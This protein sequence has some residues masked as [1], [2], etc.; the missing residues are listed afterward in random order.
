MR[1]S[2]HS[3]HARGDGAPP[4]GGST[5]RDF[6]PLPSCEG[7]QNEDLE[8]TVEVL[9]QS[10]P[11]MR[12]E[13]LYS[14]QCGFVKAFQSTPLMRGETKAALWPI[15]WKIISIH[16]PH[17]R[18]DGCRAGRLAWAGYFNPLPSCEGRRN[19]CRITCAR[20]NNFNPLPSCE[21]RRRCAR[22]TV[23]GQLFQSTPL[24]RGETRHHAKGAALFFISIHSPHARG[25]KG[26]NRFGD[27]IE[28]SIHSPHARGD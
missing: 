17:A 15:R 28:I 5:K 19:A 3:P 12:G 1:I 21:G 27:T 24:M 6:N 8:M 16:S 11:L 10:T 20:C 14:N 26:T 2:I 25:D 13:T 22:T 7:R 9:F 4:E 23:R 18:G